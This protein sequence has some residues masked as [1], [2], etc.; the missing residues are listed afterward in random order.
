MWQLKTLARGLRHPTHYVM[1]P[2]FLHFNERLTEVHT[3]NLQ[4]VAVKILRSN[5]VD[6]T[7]NEFM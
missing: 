5:S 3:R 6:H 7:V 1:A 4:G 2:K